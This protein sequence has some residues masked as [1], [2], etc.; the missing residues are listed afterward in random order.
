MSTTIDQ[1]V[2]EMRFDNAEF[3]RNVS[4]SISSL[5][6]LKSSL[7]FSGLSNGLDRVGT[8]ISG[9]SSKLSPLGEIWRRIWS[10]VGN[11][12]FETI[13][14]V[15]NAI[16]SLGF[17][18][19]IAGFNKYTLLSKSIQT[20][21]SSTR[22]DWDD[23]SA[24]MKYVS[25]QIN[26]LS[27]FTDETSYNLTDM[28]NNIGKFVAAGVDLEDAV[29]AMMGIATWAGIS[30]SNIQQASNAM[31]NLSQAMGVGY[32]RVIDWMSIE[33]ANMATREFKE[34]VI[35]T[36]AQLGKLTVN[37]KG[38]YFA[39]KTGKKAAEEVT[40]DTLRNTLSTKWF[41]QDVLTAILK[42]YGDFSEELYKQTNITRMNATELLGDLKAYR[43]VLKNVDKTA[44]KLGTKDT[45]SLKKHII[46]YYRGILN[47][48]KTAKE[49]GVTVDEL[50]KSFAEYSGTMMDY[51]KIKNDFDGDTKSAIEYQ[52][53]LISLSKSEYE[54]GYQALKASQE[55]RTLEDSI[56]ATKDAISSAWMKVFTEVLGDYLES[57]DLW[58]TVSEEL[59]DVFVADI[60]ALYW[61]IKEWGDLGGREI[62][63]DGIETAWYAIKSAIEAVKGGISEIF[64]ELSGETLV[65]IT[66][67]FRDFTKVLELNDLQLLQLR[68]SGQYVANVVKN[69]STSVKRL[70]KALVEAIGEIFP[71]TKTATQSIYEFF[72]AISKLSDKFVITEDRAGKLKSVFKGLLSV[73]DIVKQLVVAILKQFIGFDDT[74]SSLGDSILDVSA[75]FGDWLTNLDKF[76]KENDVFGK[77]IET[78]IGFF[79]K[80]KQNIDDFIYAI[81]NKHL[82]DVWEEIKTN[83]KAAAGDVKKFFEL[84]NS[85][86]SDGSEKKG[87][88]VASIFEKISEAVKK[89]QK[90]FE[91]AQPYIDEINKTLGETFDVEFNGWDDFSEAFRKGGALTVAIFLLYDLIIL[92]QYLFTDTPRLL[93]NFANSITAVIDS[94]G[95]SMW[96]ISERIKAGT[97]TKIARAILY[98]AIAIALVA[99]IKSE[100]LEDA[101]MAMVLL[102]GGLVAVFLKF[103]QASN[104]VDTANLL[105]IAIAMKSMAKAMVLVA[106]SIGIVA[107]AGADGGDVVGAAEAIVVLFG[108][109]AGAMWV[110]NRTN[111]DTKKIRSL[112]ATM[113]LLGFAM[114]EIGVSLAIVTAASKDSDKLDD[115]VVA[116][117]AMVVVIGLFFAAMSKN[118]INPGKISAASAAMALVG[119]AL[120]EISAALAI[121]VTAAKD[122]DKIGEAAVAISG[123]IFVLGMFFTAMSG[124]EIDAGKIIASA[125]AL[126]LVGV[127]LILIAASI[128][129]VSSVA[130]QEGFTDGLAGL[131]AMLVVLALVLGGLSTLQGGIVEGAASITIASIG[132]LLLAKALKELSG[133]NNIDPVLILGAALMVLIGAAILAEK[134]ATGLI[135]LGGAL[136]LIG[137]G[138]LASGTGMLKFAEGMTLLIAA[139]KE[140]VDVMLYFFE[141]LGGVLPGLLGSFGEGIVN[142]LS[143]IFIDGAAVLQEALTNLGAVMLES[144]IILLPLLAELLK[145]IVLTI[146]D[147][148]IEMLP[149]LIDLLVFVTKELLRSMMEITPM[150][151]AAAIY[152]LIDTLKQIAANIAEV[153]ALLIEIAV[154]TIVGTI[155]GIA[156][157]IPRF[158]HVLWEFIIQL[159]NA[160][161]DGIEAH[162]VDLKDAIVHL[163]EVIVETFCALLGIHS[164]S[165]IFEGF[166]GNIIQGLINGVK[167]MISKAE[168][169]FWEFADK[170]LTAF[171]EKFGIEKKGSAKEM[172]NLAV[173]TVQGW[174]SG[175]SEW[176]GKAK[177]KISEFADKVLTKFCEIIGVEKPTDVSQFGSF[178]IKVI[179]QFN[180][181]IY[182]M[183]SKA[184]DMVVDLG[185]KVLEGISKFLG[186]DSLKNSPMYTIGIQ[187]IQGMIDGIIKKGADLTNK[188]KKVVSDAVQGIKNLLGIHSPSRVLEEVGVNTD[189]GFINGLIKHADKVQDAAT[190]VGN[191][192]IDGVTSAISNISQMVEEGIDAQPTIRPVLDLSNVSDGIGMMDDMM[193]ANRTVGLASST[194]FGFNNGLADKM[195]ASTALDNL[196]ATISGD[197]RPGD[198]INNTFNITGDDPRAIAEEVGNILQADVER[199]NAVWGR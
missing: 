74:A 45:E 53:A 50:R 185:K 114:I 71:Q 196:M 159:I 158:I 23:Q 7:D 180:A 108:A 168:E 112:A 82:G 92:F 188:A 131:I 48:D 37:K 181:G 140:G 101:V 67:K 64:P 164:P 175:I 197:Y 193:S 1:K 152:I 189:Q 198:T 26:K 20:I 96:N 123:I 83:A 33:N 51:K 119:F 58:S 161:A 30:G 79:K 113:S 187:T 22:K 2:V 84:F 163:V 133:V 137:I 47:V 179:Q 54:L 195:S 10:E 24:Q 147:T 28:T 142:M 16:N 126:D 17:E 40:P 145:Q 99:S 12:A 5:D 120:I 15:Q 55:S 60:D 190:I 118:E 46:Q 44:E 87:L 176:I 117:G 32:V 182:S 183:V 72:R 19:V 160:I 100:K 184:K 86:E 66:E 178:A 76:I 129:M 38:Q 94:V 56:L 73:L 93:F 169:I 25:E 124:T 89:L 106:L 65:N 138:A 167:D 166:G 35:K 127:A 80:L 143:A 41:D 148:T 68:A 146:K 36:A 128:M 139:G 69:I 13:G 157:E 63:L 49:Y 57:V 88:S 151:T 141:Q 107:K 77:S 172:F 186:I 95:E 162:A 125:F 121:V 42:Q 39:P 6:S 52:N 144:A 177:E 8:S 98:L 85:S 171:C 150:V 3:E 70:A 105:K 18:Q 62:L 14:T 122:S 34:E 165:T 43:D 132:V 135:V 75:G 109:L 90:A 27:W 130:S 97:I 78:I 9:I 110:L 111:I 155:E 103:S 31:Y 174:I 104:A 11:V 134:V 61:V 21:M 115:A 154:E 4:Q 173:Q 116:L 170:V 156:A 59:W 153:T 149:I 81:T 192:A 102:M 199:R 29:S 191:T 194:G 91:E 136:A